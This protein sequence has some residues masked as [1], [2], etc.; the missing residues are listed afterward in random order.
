MKLFSSSKPKNQ[1]RG[2]LRDLVQTKGSKIKADAKADG[3]YLALKRPSLPLLK[4]DTLTHY[5]S[6][7]KARCEQVAMEVLHTSQPASHL[8]TEELIPTGRKCTINN[9]RRN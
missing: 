7:I 3:Q 5:I 6:P 8:H 4:G 9:Y 1:I 2:V